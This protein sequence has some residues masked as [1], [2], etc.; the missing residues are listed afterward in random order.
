M[1]LEL[2]PSVDAIIDIYTKTHSSQFTKAMSTMQW[3]RTVTT[4]Q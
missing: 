1:P 3:V 2:V 4:Q